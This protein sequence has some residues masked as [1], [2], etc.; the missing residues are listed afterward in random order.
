MLTRKRFLKVLGA[1]T[2]ALAGGST[3]A[4]CGDGGGDAKNWAWMG[5]GAPEDATWAERFAQIKAAG[6]DGLLLQQEDTSVLRE[7]ASIARDEGLEL[8]VWH[9]TMRSDEHLQTH[10]DWYAVNR[11]GVSTAENP[12]YVDYYHFM[13]PCVPG[14]RD[15]LANDVGTLA[16]M[17][18]VAGIHLDY[19]RFPDVILPIALQPKYD[20]EQDEEFPRFDYGYHEACRTQFAEQTG[21][22]PMDLDD[23][24]AN[25]QWVQFRYDQITQVVTRLAEVV[26]GHDKMISA[27]V[28]P[29]P[30]IARRLVRQ[31]WPEWTLD[32]VMPM[33]YHNF[34]EKDVSWIETATREG[35]DALAPDTPLYS[36]LFVP[37]LTPDQLVSAVEYARAGGASGISLFDVGSMTDA[38]WSKVGPALAA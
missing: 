30:D 5:G 19:I 14:V 27:A 28:F 22:D 35:L 11:K 32:A 17:E 13:S 9:I 18:G 33:I 2:L 31:D 26:H 37:E 20:L 34:Y 3:L 12:P 1:G 21:T 16:Q 6:V 4:G 7:V 29:T 36:G 8:H 15:Q 24:P 10:P 38:H 25:D 23:T